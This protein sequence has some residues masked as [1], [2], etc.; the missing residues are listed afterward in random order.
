MKAFLYFWKKY[1]KFTKKII[2]N[3]EIAHKIALLEKVK[4]NKIHIINKNKNT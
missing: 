3:A 2:Q 1:F 4:N